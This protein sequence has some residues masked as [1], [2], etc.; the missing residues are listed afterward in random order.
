MSHPRGKRPKLISLGQDGSPI[1]SLRVRTGAGK[2]EGLTSKELISGDPE[3]DIQTVGS[4]I[5]LESR[6]WRSKGEAN[7]SSGFRKWVTI[8]NTKGEVVKRDTYKTKLPNINADLPV[9]I[10]KRIP[11]EEAFKKVLFHNQYALH[12]EDGLQFEFLQN[13]AKSLWEKK[14]VA[15]LGA[16]GKSKEPL[17]FREGGTPY[18][19]FLY[20]EA[21]D[22]G[23]KLLVLLTRQEL[24]S[25]EK[26][27]KE[28]D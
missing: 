18:K 17:V 19:A 7:L 28:N 6:G 4:P 11:M 15:I 9:K 2:T 10:T 23:Y 26:D 24:K 20:G 1:E 3:V 13:L 8:Y 14:E 22:E 27:E 21:K 25:P 16:G 5:E 12:H